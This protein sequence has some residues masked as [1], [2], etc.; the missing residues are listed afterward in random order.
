MRA[1]VS[2]EE[3]ASARISCSDRS[4]KFLAT[5]I[6]YRIE[7]RLRYYFLAAEGAGVAEGAEVAEASGAAEAA[8]VMEAA[9][10]AEGAAVAEVS[11]ADAEAAVRADASGAAEPGGVA[12]EAGVAATRTFVPVVR[13][14]EGLTITLSD[15]VTPLR[16][17]DCMP[18]SRPTFTSWSCTTPLASTTP[19]CRFFPRK[20]RVLSGKIRTFPKA[21][22]G[23]RTVAKLPGRISFFE[24]STCNSTSM[25]RESGETAS[26]V[27]TTLP[28]YVFAL[29]APT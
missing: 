16:I 29:C 6:S 22:C 26:E 27:E 23:T 4:L 28:G 24:L 8:G 12:E 13:E 14:S 18:K 1:S 5:G 2:S 20:I 10:A 15:S 11:G 25:V 19:T 7:Q 3:I 9:G 17:S 21:L